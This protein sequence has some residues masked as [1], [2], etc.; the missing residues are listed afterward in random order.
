MA[1][2]G[3]DDI[4]DALADIFRG[5][6]ESRI[7]EKLALTEPLMDAMGLD[8]HDAFAKANA[9]VTGTKGDSN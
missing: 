5:M 9:A 8:V 2:P 7:V 4:P 1:N 6:A 3:D